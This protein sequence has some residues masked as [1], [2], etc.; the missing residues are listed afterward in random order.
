MPVA[1]MPATQPSSARRPQERWRALKA[2][3]TAAAGSTANRSPSGS[4][5]ASA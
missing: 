5:S 4:G 1:M 2:S 3:S